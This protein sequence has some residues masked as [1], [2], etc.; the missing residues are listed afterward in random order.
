M[1]KITGV[2]K[3]Q[4]RVVSKE[5]WRRLWAADDVTKYKTA[6]AATLF[7]DILLA[8]QQEETSVRHNTQETAHSRPES[9]MAAAE[10]QQ[11]QG[12]RM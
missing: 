5:Q 7:A 10:N 12:L 4:P 3:L 6:L 9:V 1:P 8:K 11:R 2:D